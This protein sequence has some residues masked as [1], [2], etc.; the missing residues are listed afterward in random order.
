MSFD[1]IN[2]SEALTRERLA[3]TKVWLIAVD[4]K[5]VWKF[6]RNKM[7]QSQDRQAE[8]VDRHRNKAGYKINDKVWLLNRNI[9]TKKPSKKLNYK[10]IGT[11]KI[12]KLVGSSYQ[13][14]LPTSM[15]I[16]D[17]F[18]PSLLQKVSV[19]PLSSQHNDLAP[20]VVV[21][22]KEK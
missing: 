16:H 22:N 8:A 21:N 4:M 10:T 18:H 20:P 15:K 14:D 9:K 2:L 1:S 3:N 12:K 19:D 5:E 6:V 11:Y 7:A 13:L 17:V